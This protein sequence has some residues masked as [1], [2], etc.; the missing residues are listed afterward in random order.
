LIKRVAD[1]ILTPGG[2]PPTP[3]ISSVK[4][5]QAAS[6]A[7]TDV[8]ISGSGFTGTTAVKLGAVSIPFVFDSDTQTDDNLPSFD[9]KERRSIRITEEPRSSQA[10]PE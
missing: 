9:G 10:L 3:V 7:Q 2:K 5:P 4:P 6:G 1:V 8:V